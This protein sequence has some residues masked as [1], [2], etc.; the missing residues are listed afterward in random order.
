M[1]SRKSS[2]SP[3]RV[4]LRTRVPL[5]GLDGMCSSGQCWRPEPQL[6][7]CPEA[8]E[9]FRGGDDSYAMEVGSLVC[10]CAFWSLWA[11]KLSE[12][13]R[14]PWCHPSLWF[15]SNESSWL[16]AGPPENT[17]LGQSFLLFWMSWEFVT[18]TES[19]AYTRPYFPLPLHWKITFLA[20]ELLRDTS[21][22]N[23]V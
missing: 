7:C 17:C 4:I 1:C 15:Q 2:I 20:S 13:P 18:V 19:W 21:N 23:V 6:Q 11:E 5:V 3:W 8:M 22:Q 16:W 10:P 12:H 9:P 14:A